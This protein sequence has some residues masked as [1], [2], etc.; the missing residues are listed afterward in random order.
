MKAEAT[1]ADVE[2]MAAVT[3]NDLEVEGNNAA[4]ATVELNAKDTTDAHDM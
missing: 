3:S 1:T 4:A 2:A